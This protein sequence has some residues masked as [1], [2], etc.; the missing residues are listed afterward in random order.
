MPT[1]PA[2]LSDVWLHGAFPLGLL[3][4]WRGEVSM[5]GKVV[6]VILAVIGVMAI[7]AQLFRGFWFAL[8]GGGPLF[9]GIVVICIFLLGVF[10]GSSMKR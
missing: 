4:S 10:V 1:V 3:K 2:C 9:L 8:I 7:C 6:L 5:D